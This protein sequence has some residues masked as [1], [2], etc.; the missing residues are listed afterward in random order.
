[1]TAAPS[2]LAMLIAYKSAERYMYA[3]NF[4]ESRFEKVYAI[5]IGVSAHNG[6]CIHPRNLLF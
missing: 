3:P 4:L 6:V 1:M 2:G 5:F